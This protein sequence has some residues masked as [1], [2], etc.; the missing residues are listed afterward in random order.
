MFLNPQ[1]TKTAIIYASH[2][3]YGMRGVHKGRPTTHHQAAQR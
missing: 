1:R 2:P 3:V